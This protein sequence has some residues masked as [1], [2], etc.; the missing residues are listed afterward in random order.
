MAISY[1]KVKSVSKSM[2]VR[3]PKLTKLVLETMKTISDL[4]GATLG[5]GG[6]PVL[7]ERQELDLPALVTKD[8]VTCF[9][10]LGFD[11][12][13]QHV[14]MEAM[15]DASTRTASEAGDGTT[16]ATVLAEAIARF[17]DAY[18]KAN[19]KVSAQKVVRKLQGT[20]SNIILPL[21]EKHSRKADLSTEEGRK[22]LLNVAKISANGDS[23]LAAAVLE[24]FDAVG[25]EG[26]VT[27][28]EI[29]GPSGFEVEKIDGF[30]IPMGIEDSCGKYGSKFINEPAMQMC[31]LEQPLFVV[32]HGRITEIQSMVLLMEQIAAQWQSEKGWRHNVV[33]VA[34][35]FS[36]S[37]LAQLALNFAEMTTINVFPLLAPQSPIPNGQLGFLED[38]CAVTGAKL[39][40]PLNNPLDKAELTDLGVMAKTFEANR[41][42]ST[43]LSDGSEDTALVIEDQVQRLQTQKTQAASI[44]DANIY[45][46]RIGK[47]T[48][49][50]AKLKVVGSSSG[51]LRERRDRAEDAI[52]AVRGA[53][54]HGCLPGGGWMLMRIADALSKS[55]DDVVQQVLIPALL[56]P[57]DR[58]LSNCGFTPEES[59]EISSVVK[60]AIATED[61]E[62]VYDAFD[63]KFVNPWGEEV[64]AKID[65]K[66]VVLWQDGVVDSTPAVREALKNSLSIASLLGTLGAT[67]VFKRDQELERTE[68]RDTASFLR[69]AE[70]EG[71]ADKRA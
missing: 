53:I 20:F 50:I 37:V 7:I 1:Q 36:E 63:Q 32:F 18:M 11:D 33:V 64:K 57:I 40:D 29:S 51:E 42:R 59:E 10:A 69:D 6:M 55:K 17:A 19:P 44:L 22:L 31:R 58:L 54:K 3:G 34:T 15:R 23:E 47:L 68:A 30:P 56:V 62:L 45:D 21:I 49:G 9:R 43:I 25:D 39:L 70:S 65:G 60:A 66:D 26:N 12:P 8:G 13:T 35:G 46:E 5:P 48:G 38:V 41:F 24:C 67:I 28:T 27:L 16:T 71:E 4:V 52:C 14:I 61:Y 2:N